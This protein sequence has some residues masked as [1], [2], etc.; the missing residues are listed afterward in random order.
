MLPNF[1]IVGAAKAATTSLH[2][3]L[4]KHPDVFMSEPKE[5]NYFSQEELDAQQLYYDDYKPAS[6]DEY[7]KLFAHAS[8][9]KAIGEASVSYLFYPT[10]P[11]K[12]KNAVPNAKIIILLRNPFERSFSHYLMDY[13]LGL[14]NCS[15]DDVLFNQHKHKNADLFYQ[16]YIE[17]SL[18]AS[19]VER[20]LKT[21]GKENVKILLQEDLRKNPEATM[22]EVFSFLGIDESFQL[23]FWQEHNAFNMPKNAL[24]HRFY[25][26]AKLRKLLSII[27][28]N[29]IKQ[30]VIK[31]F[32]ETGTK[33]QM[34]L[35]AKDALSLIYNPDLKALE[36]L[37]KHNFSHWIETKNE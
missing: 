33:P 10:V 25:R 31:L 4:S 6:L 24:I 2:Y 21:F 28:P 36:L 34:S 23:D 13:R 3:Y 14:C 20:Y 5:I 18:Y 22:K 37:T 9:K 8:H 29:T 16:Q 17:L 19:Q 32:F 11:Q 12:I 27:F 1:F 30:Q 7:K 26:N 35:K 15:F